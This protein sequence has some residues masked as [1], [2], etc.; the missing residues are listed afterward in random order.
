MRGRAKPE[1]AVCFAILNNARSFW[2]GEGGAL[3]QPVSGTIM[4]AQITTSVFGLKSLSLPRRVFPSLGMFSPEAE[5]SRLATTVPE[6]VV[7][8]R[9][10][11]GQ[12]QLLVQF[13]FND[14]IA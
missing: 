7:G 12:L 5:E 1:I 4:Y 3:R 2:A 11:L 10:H 8:G 14:V 9:R 6:E 13:L